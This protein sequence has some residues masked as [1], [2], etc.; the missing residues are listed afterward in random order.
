MKIKPRKV[1]KV[2]AIIVSILVIIVLVAINILMSRYDERKT[3]S[4]IESRSIPY[5]HAFVNY[6]GYKI[7]AYCIGDPV[8]PKALFIHG[9]PGHWVDWKSQYID[10]ELLENYCMIAYDRPGYGETT[11]PASPSLEL[12]ADVAARVMKYFCD[13]RECFV[14]S[15]HSYGGGVVEKLLIDHPARANKGIYVA[16]TL[17]PEHQGKRWYNYLAAFK[18]VQWIIPYE[19]TSSNI[20]MMP[21]RTE[22]EKNRGMQPRITQPLVLIQGT[23][24]VLVPFK[25]VDYYRSVKPE[26]VEYMIVEGM[27]HFVPWTN[28][29][30]IS[31]AILEN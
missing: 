20:E 2:I 6:N 29:E 27:N 7:N 21:L 12:Q 8:L 17:S 11:M 15:G 1:L 18:P 9:S 5:R 24:D 13:E 25:T 3:L 31:R 26:G 16:G 14:V 4:E 10:P 28:P 23:K 30:L 19:F 22:L